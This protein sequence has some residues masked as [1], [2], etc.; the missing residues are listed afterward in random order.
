[1]SVDPLIVKF[2]S[3]GKLLIKLRG[4]S[5]HLT[6]HPGHRSGTMD[7]HRTN[8]LCPCGDPSRYETV[9]TLTKAELVERMWL[10]G[11]DLCLEALTLFGASEWDERA[12]IQWAAK[13]Q[14]LFLK[15][16]SPLWN[17]AAKLA[18]RI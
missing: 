11:T 7:L 3:D 6:L 13:W 17:R 10:F 9:G 14:P 18:M 4:Q 8:E 2:L 15:L 1:M 5:C 12:A 16:F